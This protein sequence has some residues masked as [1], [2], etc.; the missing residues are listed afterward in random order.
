MSIRSFASGLLRLSAMSAGRRLLQ[1][2]WTLR[3]GQ[4]IDTYLATNAVRKLQIGTGSQP[5]EGWLNTDLAPER[6]KVIFMDATRRFPLP[7]NSF[8]YIFTEHI[9]EHLSYQD[10][11]AMLKE[12]LRVLRPGGRMRIATPDLQVLLSLNTSHH[13]EMQLRYLQWITANFLPHL[14]ESNAVIVINNAF[15]NWGHQFLYDRQLLSTLLQQIG[16]ADI[17]AYESGQSGD[18]NLTGI[19]SHGYAVAD[20]EMNRFESMILEARKPA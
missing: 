18:P 19:D 17:T 5:L 6:P 8:E 1:F 4:Q 10:G 2:Q 3:R 12:S 9:I 7:D 11:R 15:R 20:Q 14:E 16:F 13:S